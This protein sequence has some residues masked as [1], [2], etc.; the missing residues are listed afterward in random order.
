MDLTGNV[1]LIGFSSKKGWAKV[2]HLSTGL[3][4]GKGGGVSWGNVLSVNTLN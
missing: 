1:N 3:F 4:L 2:H